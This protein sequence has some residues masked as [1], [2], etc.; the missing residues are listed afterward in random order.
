MSWQ[1]ALNWLH[2]GRT[3][4]LNQ[5]PID[6][7]IR[8]EGQADAVAAGYA[9][10]TEIFATVLPTLVEE[11]DVLRTPLSTHT[12]PCQ[13]PVAQRMLA[14]CKPFVSHNVTPMSAVAGAVADH[15]LHNISSV[16]GLSRCWVN[17]GGDIAIFLS[18]SQSFDCGIV[19]NLHTGTLSAQF[20]FTD[21]DNVR[22]V[23]TSGRATSADGGRSFSLGIADAVTVLAETAS[24]ADVAAT[25]IANQVDLP[26]HPAVSRI[27]ANSLDPDSDLQN[28]QVTTGVGVLSDAEI[29]LAL[30]RGWTLANKFL[31]QNLI[32]SALLSL[33]GTYR[34]VQTTHLLSE[35]A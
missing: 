24:R 30:Q 6:L 33:R 8:C 21:K 11:L 20:Q 7:L 17:N 4:H 27:A 16:P 35:T 10:A 19:D 12:L 34:R 28:R 18:E 1:P 3:L 22:G 2:Q 29:N 5:G 32:H 13:G 25:L 9:A 23:A 26:D 15:V 31:Q 14:A